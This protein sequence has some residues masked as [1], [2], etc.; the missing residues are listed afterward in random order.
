MSLHLPFI[1]A[2]G[3]SIDFKI[4]KCGTARTNG[5]WVEFDADFCNELDDL[6]LVF[7]VAHETLHKAFRHPWRRGSRHPVL[8]NMACDYVINGWLRKQSSSVLVLPK[9]VLHNHH[10]TELSEEAVYEELLKS[11]KK[12]PGNYVI[13]LVDNTERSET[14]VEVEIMNIAKACKMAGDTSGLLT[15]ILGDVGKSHVPWQEIT[16]AFVTAS[17]A[18]GVDWMRRHRRHANIYIPTNKRRV[19]EELVVFTDVSGSMWPYLKEVAT[20]LNAIVIDAAPKRTHVI[21]GDV[22]VHSVHTYEYGDTVVFEAKGG[23]GTD[24]RPLFEEVEKRN[25]S[26]ACGIFLTD[27]YGDFPARS[28]AYPVLWGVIGAKDIHVPWGEVVR[29]RT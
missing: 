26:P 2:V 14:D 9:D 22:K 24:F 20:E 25:W 5:D 1:S 4:G 12:I 29:V 6:E 7:L 17:V 28:P 18:G 3:A 13:D 16:R 10:Y 11:A 23:G 15:K 19:L 8:W 27:T 21:C